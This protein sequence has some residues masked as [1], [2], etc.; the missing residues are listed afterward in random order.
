MT[1][2]PAGTTT[3]LLAAQYDLDPEYASKL[4][5]VTTLASVFTVPLMISLI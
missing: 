2:M 3:A 4:V 5:F 1:A